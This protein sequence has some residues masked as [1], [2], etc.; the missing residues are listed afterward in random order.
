MASGI[1]PVPNN[2]LSDDHVWRDWF[3]TIW[4]ALGGSSSSSSGKIQ[5]NSLGGLQGGDSEAGNYYHLNKDQYDA[6]NNTGTVGAYSTYTGGSSANTIYQNTTTGVIQVII[7][8]NATAWMSY[9]AVSKD[10]VTYTTLLNITYASFIM[11]VSLAP[12]D[13]LA[14]KCV[15]SGTGGTGSYTNVVMPLTV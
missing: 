11:T 2:P 12:G 1:P 5:H 10:G 7:N 6:I 4:Q 3:Y 9:I 13:Y 14:T 8:P 15:A